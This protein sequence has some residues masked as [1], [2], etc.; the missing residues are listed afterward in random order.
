MTGLE[1]GFISVIG[2]LVL[3]LM[4][5]NI[6]VVLA[7]VSLSG[8]WFIT[9]NF[10]IAIFLLSQ[11]SVETISSQEFAVIPL[12]VLMGLLIS[13]SD[14][15]RETF[16]VAHF[17]FRKIAGGLGV[18]T[19]AANAIFA[20]ITGVSIASAAVFTQVAVPEMLRYGYHPRLAVGI[21]AGS[22][23]LGMLIPPSI[24]LIVYAFIAE[25]SVGSL[26]IAAIIPGLILAALYAIAI[27]AVG[28]LRPEWVGQ[29]EMA[30]LDE[31]SDMTLGQAIK[32]LAPIALLVLLVIGGIY[33]GV[34]TPTESGAVGAAGALLLT[35]AK[36]RLTWSTFWQVTVQTGHVTASISFMI[37]AA[38]MYSSML[39]L[40]GVPS[41][42]QTWVSASSFSVITLIIVYVVIVIILG[43]LLDSISIIL[44]VLPIFVP[45]FSQFGVDL[46][47]LGILSIIIVEVGLLTPPLGIAVFVVKGCLPDKQISLKDIF[48]GAMPFGLIM[49]LVVLLIVVFPGIIVY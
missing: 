40:S 28:K 6:P 48:L 29:A 37:I 39:G 7:L 23:V 47:W 46:V 44:I 26:F 20:S 11:K 22:S 36:R 41:E 13:T 15:A 14:I 5:M 42:L 12:F 49:L 16:G 8:I 17:V 18:A 3:V 9:D 35:I 27:L 25:V 45:L 32:L 2:I 19:V 24:L 31:T 10:D 21:V 38:S 1:I 30:A 4:G 43:M 34:F 33:R